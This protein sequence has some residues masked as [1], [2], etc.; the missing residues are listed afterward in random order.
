M[1]L[2]N[3]GFAITGILYTLLVL[4]LM[5]LISVLAELNIRKKIMEK[6]IETLEDK[7][8]FIS[9]GH[10]TEEKEAPETGKYIFKRSSPNITCYAYIAKGT[11]LKSTDIQYTTSDCNN[12]NSG[13]ILSE[14]CKK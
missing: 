2:N 1:K 3:K 7:Y 6:S 12:D 10:T 11:T 4:F 9:C 13:L 8:E 14:Y 5:T